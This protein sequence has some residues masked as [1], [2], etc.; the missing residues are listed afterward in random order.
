M[1]NLFDRYS[2]RAR[3]YPSLILLLPVWVFLY[4]YWGIELD[5]L[6]KLLLQ[7]GLGLAFIF[8]FSELVIRNWG[9]VFENQIFKKGMDFP[10]TRWLMKGDKT[11]GEQRKKALYEKIKRDFDYDLSHN[12]SKKDIADSVSQIR[13]RVGSGR[14]TLQYLERYGAWRNLSSSSSFSASIALALTIFLLIN[15][16]PVWL[17]EVILSIIFLFIFLFRK[18][19]I[20]YLA[21]EY[22][23][24]VFNEY[25][26]L[27]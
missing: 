26:A 1:K 22:A 11:L 4:G 6:E 13:L 12:T 5:N 3:L 18:K 15:N 25:L 16:N 8:L 2:R 23:E 19:V 9:K 21:E 10:T 17:A 7:S 27:K 20:V 24:Q 14:L